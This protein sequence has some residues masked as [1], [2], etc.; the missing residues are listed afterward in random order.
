MI[1]PRIFAAVAAVLS[2]GAG[3]ASATVMF[4]APGDLVCKA[5]SCFGIERDV[6]ASHSIDSISLDRGL[7][8]DLG[9]AL[10]RITLWSPDGSTMVGDFG[11]FMLSVLGGDTLTLNGRT[12]NLDGL[13]E[14]MVRIDRVILGGSGGP[15]GGSFG[16]ESFGG[17]PITHSDDGPPVTF[18]RSGSD[19]GPP[20][21]NFSGDDTSLT[22]FALAPTVA[23][24]PE[25]TGWVLLLLGFAALGAAARRRA[26][27]QRA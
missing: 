15:G 26:R 23:A 7:L 24:V 12:I 2:L 20:T 27:T 19:G 17:A 25:P 5:D 11:D 14:V 10:V 21:G 16:F 18:G 22:S 8:G 1:H 13:G 4:Q 3:S 9:G 6:G